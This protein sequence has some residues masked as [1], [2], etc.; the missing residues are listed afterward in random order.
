MAI[1]NSTPVQF[2]PVGLSDAT[3]QTSSFPG[4]CQ[5]VS[6]LIFDRDNRGAVIPRPAVTQESNFSGFTTPGVISVMFEAGTLIY[7]L[8][9]T[10]RN[11]GFDEPFC[12]DT[13]TQ[14]FITVGGVTGANVPATQL[15]TG[16]WV[17][18]TMDAMGV[19]VIVTHPGFSGANAFGWFNVT[20]P[21][22]PTWNAGN[23][24]VN[25][26]PSKPQWVIQ[27]FGRAYFGIANNVYFTD[28]LAL[29]ISAPNFA[30]VLTLGDKSP[31]TGVAGLPMGQTAGAVLQSIVIFKQS[32]VWQVSGDIAL[33]TN[34]LLLQRI[35]DNVGCVSPRTIQSTPMGILF[36]ANDGPRMI[37]LSGTIGYLQVRDGVTPDIVNPFATV[38][39]VT[40]MVGAYANGIYR[41]NLVGPNTIW[42]SNYTTQ[43]YWYDFIFQRW[44]GPHSFSYQCAIGVGNTFYLGADNNSGILIASTVVPSQNTIYQDLATTDILCEL[45]SGAIE[46]VPM[47]MSCV[48]ESTIELG[49]A[50]MGI[51]YYISMYDDENNNLAPATIKLYDENPLWGAVKWGQFRW[52]SAMTNSQVF[53]IPWNNPVVF[54]KMIFSVRVSSAKNVSIKS[55]FFR[56]Q[57]LGYMNA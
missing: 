29:S 26:L 39:N 55:S 30:A 46:G 17:P 20:N 35:G 57:T 23:T 19:F 40:R 41:V 15:T 37:N 10:A 5:I 42:D 47:T 8:I 24:T 49:G 3:D 6:N 9:G 12:Y 7:G 4:S 27:F 16:N 28:S 25:A 44:N 51:P 48:V 33:T 34:P 13:A 32:E 38:T 21:A 1:R 36:I 2:I 18:P 53:T 45:V 50:G 54:K 22:A 56:V 43:D 31:S 11:P 52:R 14:T